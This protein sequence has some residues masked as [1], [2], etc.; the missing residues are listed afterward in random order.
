MAKLVLISFA[1]AAALTL[2]CSRARPPNRESKS[3]LPSRSERPWKHDEAEADARAP[4]QSLSVRVNGEPAAWS[5]AQL[6][7]IATV[8]VPSKQGPNRQGW[9]LGDMARQLLG[10]N[11]HV[12]RILGDGNDRLDVG[13]HDSV[14][15]RVTRDGSYKAIRESD[16]S[17]LRPVREVEIQN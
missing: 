14:F 1:A 12:V 2:S 3:G 15:L 13:P 10:P 8:S 17:V 6:A 9:L 4:S 16:E 11:A 7:L 5:T